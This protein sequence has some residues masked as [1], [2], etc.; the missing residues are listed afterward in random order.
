MH[1]LTETLLPGSNTF[2]RYVTR[3]LVLALAATTG[4][5]AALIWLIQSLHFITLVVD[6][7][8]SL[9]GFLWLTGL[10]VPSFVAVIL[11]ITTFLVVQF[12]YSRLEGDRELTALRAAGRSPFALARPA[13]LVAL[14]AVM[15]GYMLNIWI[16]PASYGAFREREFEIRNS[17]AA[18]LLQ[19]GVFTRVSPD[20]TVYVRRRDPNGTL[21]GILVDDA[22]NKNSHATILA[23]SGRLIQVSGHPEVLL[24]NGSRQEI[25]KQTGRLDMLTF[26]QNT[27]DLSRKNKVEERDRDVTEMSI[28]ELLHPADSAQAP[29]MIVEANRRLSGPLTAGSLALVAL[30]GV[31]TGAFRRN[32]TVVRP[33]ATVAMVLVIMAG[34]LAI[35][36]LA[37]RHL[38]LVPLIWIEA[39]APGLI[40]LWLLFAEPI[41]AWLGGSR[42]GRSREDPHPT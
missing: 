39:V 3:Q 8:L 18:F 31:L 11:P 15:T 5:L 21:H 26:A 22:R 24:L 36:N 32:A 41:F 40:C 4:G 9:F 16:L 35:G 33:L 2:D 30:V 10:L 17:L 42:T 29:K 12:I 37:A 19:D 1:S 6:R 13:L 28:G 34:E 25:D 7:G 27:I 14:L 20:L 23:E 38:A